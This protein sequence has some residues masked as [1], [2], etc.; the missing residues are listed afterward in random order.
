MNSSFESVKRDDDSIGIQ[1]AYADKMSEI[2][3]KHEFNV[4]LDS[5]RGVLFI[6]SLD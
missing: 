5:V 4:H 3:L 6:G 2:N 1:A